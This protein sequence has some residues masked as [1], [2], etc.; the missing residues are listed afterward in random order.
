MNKKLVLKVFTILL[1]ISLSFSNI[2]LF[3]KNKK[4]DY[5]IL[6]GTPSTVYENIERTD[7]SSPLDNK[8]ELNLIIF[9]LISAESIE[10]PDI[11][12]TLPYSTIHF[13]DWD[14]GICY[15]I[16]DIWIDKDD[17]IIGINTNSD[18]TTYKKLTNSDLTD[19]KNIL[20]KYRIIYEY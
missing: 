2:Y 4:L 20:E 11:S 10:K 19:F 18:N 9:P 7:F 15:F 13:N 17:V 12:K 6:I 5:S 16:V 1:I 8:D 14:K 3:N